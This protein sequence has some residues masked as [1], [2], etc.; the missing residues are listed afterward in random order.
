MEF[1]PRETRLSNVEEY[2]RKI[3]KTVYDTPSE[4]ERASFERSL[5]RTLIDLEERVEKEKLALTR[6]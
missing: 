2:A 5:Q 6:V 3:Q 1:T 4:A